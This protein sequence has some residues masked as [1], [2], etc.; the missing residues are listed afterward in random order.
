M[1]EALLRDRLSRLG[2]GATVSSAGLISEDV[3][4]SRR[5]VR[6]MARRGLDI[7]AHRSALVTL[8]RVAEA[9]LVLGLA[10][11]HVREA[12]VLVP[13][14][15]SRTFTLRE[16]VRRG[17]AVGPRR[18][19]ASVPD[20][21]AHESPGVGQMEPLERWLARVSMGRKT[22]DLL[23]PDAIDDVPDPMGMSQRTYERTAREIEDLV[24][25]LVAVAFRPGPTR[26]PS[27]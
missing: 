14:G 19:V 10:R 6:A 3:P 5:S 24:D 22:S 8:Q 26:L 9:D 20:G 7:D 13:E 1:V 25:R 4:A 15:F 16:V 17:E 23:G 12:V 2:I 21:P 11:E 18:L 27:L